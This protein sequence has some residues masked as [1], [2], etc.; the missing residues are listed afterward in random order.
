M[1]YLKHWALNPNKDLS[2]SLKWNTKITTCKYRYSFNQHSMII[3]I[4]YTS[5]YFTE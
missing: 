3:E 4:D 1:R 5:K 2:L